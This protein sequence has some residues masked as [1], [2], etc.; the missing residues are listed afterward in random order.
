MRAFTRHV[1]WVRPVCFNELEGI[2][3]HPTLVTVSEHRINISSFQNDS[4]IIKIWDEYQGFSL[5]L[6]NYTSVGGYPSEYWNLYTRHVTHVIISLETYIHTSHWIY[7]SHTYG[8][9]GFNTYAHKCNK[10]YI[11]TSH[12]IYTFHTY[13]ISGFNT[14]VHK[15]TK[16]AYLFHN[17]TIMSYMYCGFVRAQGMALCQAAPSHYLCQC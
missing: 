5:L 3:Q 13:G 1:S 9:S 8:I 15:C 10:T 14:H 16:T 2:R 7:T 17:K 4:L 11:D 12:Q 6:N